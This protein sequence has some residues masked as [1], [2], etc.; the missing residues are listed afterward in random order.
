M[1][2][3][4]FNPTRWSM[5]VDTL[6]SVLAKYEEIID[7]KEIISLRSNGDANKVHCIA[8]CGTT[9]PEFCRPREEGSTEGS[10]CILGEAYEEMKRV[11][12][13]IAEQRIGMQ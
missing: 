1:Y 7:T 2:L 8:C 3:P 5:K 11:R 9:P 12:K 13:C 10:K 4:K 6:S